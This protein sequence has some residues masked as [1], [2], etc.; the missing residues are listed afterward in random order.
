MSFRIKG[1]PA[2]HFSH[3]FAMTDEELAKHHWGAVQ[4]MTASRDIPAG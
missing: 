1:L 4:P 3:L 2:E